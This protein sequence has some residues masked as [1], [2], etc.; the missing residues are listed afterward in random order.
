[1]VGAFVEGLLAERDAARSDRRYSDADRIRD[2]LS[3]AGIEVRDTPGG[4][5]WVIQD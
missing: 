1:V 2:L 5:E 3:S 4:T